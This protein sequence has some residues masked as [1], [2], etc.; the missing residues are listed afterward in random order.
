LF[1]AETLTY[2]VTD[3]GESPANA[4]EVVPRSI[5]VTLKPYQIVTVKIKNT[6]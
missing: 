6:K 2:L 3:L 5:Y 1:T 4:F